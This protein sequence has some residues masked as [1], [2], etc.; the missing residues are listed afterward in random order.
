MFKPAL[1]DSR[2]KLPFFHKLTWILF[3]AVAARVTVRWH[4]GG[5]DFWENGYTLFFALAK[6]IAAGNGLAFDGGPPTA[7]RVPL[8]PLFLAWVTWGHQAF[9]PVLLAQSIIGAGTVWCAAML[10]KEMFGHTAAIIAA[11]LTALYP[12]Y[13]VHDTALQET[14][15]FTFLT[16]LSVLLLLRARRSGSVLTASCAGLAAGAALLTRAD[17]RLAFFAPLWLALAG[18]THAATWPQRLSAAVVC[19][20]VAALVVSPWL[21]RSYVLTGSATLNTVTGFTLWAGN[22]PYTFS[23][24]PK[25]SI[26]RSDAV[27]SDALSA[28]EREELEFRSS[29]EALVDQWFRDQGLNY[30]RQDP[31]RTLGNGL[32][33]TMAAFGWL[34]SPRRTFWPNLIHLLSYGPVMILGLWGM[35]LK[36]R[37]WREHSIFYALFISFA[38]VTA[39][40]FGHTSHRAHLDLYWIVFAAGA[41]AEVRTKY[42]QSRSA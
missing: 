3:L 42:F 26:D 10:A 31:W 28:H 25:E 18:G 7:S 14:S 33:K 8:Y 32:R 2:D 12:Y 30:M 19:G 15:L 20:I 36:R 16:A 35:W 21:V 41:L 9:L 37:N 23:H 38:I 1:S 6:N 24:Y 39:I 34:P 40:F 29:N 4:S 27:A 11:I 13:V 5:P 22:N 17:P